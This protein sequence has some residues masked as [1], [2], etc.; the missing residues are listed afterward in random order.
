M[1]VSV[2][3]DGKSLEELR[4]LRIHLADFEVKD[5]IGRGHFGD[6][7]VVRD[8][9]T[10]TVYAMKT[11]RKQETLAQPEVIVNSVFF[12][13]GWDQGL[14]DWEF[15]FDRGLDWEFWGKKIRYKLKETKMQT[16]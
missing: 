2:F 3:A 1:N 6:V 13:L 9:H 11:L 5:I 7:Q 16:I 14:S 12:S 15:S 10:E 8:L 4:K